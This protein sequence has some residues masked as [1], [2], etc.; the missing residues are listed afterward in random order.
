MSDQPTLDFQV[1]QSQ[2]WASTHSQSRFLYFKEEHLA[3]QAQDYLVFVG[4]VKGGV[5]I[6]M[7]VFVESGE[8]MSPLKGHFGGVEIIGKPTAQPLS[9]FLQRSL[10]ELRLLGIKNFRIKLYAGCY[11]EYYG[12]LDQSLIQNGF[13]R[14]VVDRNFHIPVNKK[15]FFDRLHLSEQRKLN[16]CKQSLFTVEENKDFLG[17]VYGLIK[18]LREAKGYPLLMELSDIQVLFDR[19]PENHHVF[20]VLDGDELI[21]ASICIRNHP[22]VLYSFMPGHERVYNSYS[23]LVL[24]YDYVYKYCQERQI[25]VLD[26]GIATDNGVDNTGLIRFKKNLGALETEKVIYSIPLSK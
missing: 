20:V 14:D 7:P 9:E 11:T 21:A 25:K 23:P 24:L 19:F 22:G 10:N 2:D 8:A 1:I 15:P 16:K 26:L 5:E 18:T 17:E 4:T 6:T 12:L 13:R 3:L